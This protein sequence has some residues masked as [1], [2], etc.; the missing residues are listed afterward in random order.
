MT[1]IWG[2]EG[3]ARMRVSLMMGLMFIMCA[4]ASVENEE[5][6]TEVDEMGSFLETCEMVW[7]LGDVSSRRT[8]IPKCHLPSR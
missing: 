4:S 2:N 3:R 6:E 5:M 8:R 7:Y 1:R